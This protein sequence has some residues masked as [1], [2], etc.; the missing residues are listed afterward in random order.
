MTFDEIIAELH[1]LG[2]AEK[3]LLKEKKFGI[4][5]KN[6]LGI[7]HE[8]LKILAKTIGKNNDLAIKLFDSGIYEA[9][10]LEKDKL[11]IGHSNFVNHLPNRHSNIQN[12]Q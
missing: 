5:S 4:V 1:G 7:Y 6:A 12:I 10:I 9:K 2:N 11:R 3:V 8:D